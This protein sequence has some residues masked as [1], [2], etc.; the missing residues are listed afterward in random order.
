MRLSAG[1]WERAPTTM[2][3]VQSPRFNVI[4]LPRASLDS[5][6]RASHRWPVGSAA[7]I[8]RWQE[9]RRGATSLRGTIAH[10][11]YMKNGRSS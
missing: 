11:W 5:M 9:R 6:N 4:G 2:A 1:R 7:P 8:H 3:M 10:C